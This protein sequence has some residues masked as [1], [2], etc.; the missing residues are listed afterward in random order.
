MTEVKNFIPSYPNPDDPGL[1]V[2]ISHLE[3]FA[4]LQLDVG[5]D[6]PIVV[7]PLKHQKSQ[8]RYYNVNTK[9]NRGRYTTIR[10]L[11]KRVPHL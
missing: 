4:E 8:A 9:N 1:V 3:E 2:N 6:R 10:E 11:E 5:E 7:G